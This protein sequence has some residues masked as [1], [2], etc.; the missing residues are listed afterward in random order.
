MFNIFFS[1]RKEILLTCQVQSLNQLAAFK[2][3]RHMHNANA[4]PKPSLLRAWQIWSFQ[5][6]VWCDVTHFQD[7]AW[8][9]GV[10]T[11]KQ[12]STAI[13]FHPIA[14]APGW[15]SPVWMRITPNTPLE[16]CFLL[17]AL[18]FV[19][20]IATRHVWEKNLALMAKEQISLTNRAEV[21]TQ[22]IFRHP[23]VIN[24]KQMKNIRN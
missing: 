21:C 17:N 16:G 18:F 8:L 15:K 23:F 4:R 3:D 6:Y 7:G 24:Y 20:N 2:F 11:R 14:F 1:G 10:R 12:V 19:G 22:V 9:F 5:S 13:F